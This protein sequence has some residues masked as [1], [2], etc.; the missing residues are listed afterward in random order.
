MAKYVAKPYVAGTPEAEVLGASMIAFTQNL[1][2]DMMQPILEKFNMTDIDPDGWYPHQVWMDILKTIEDTQGAAT[3]QIFV[4]F[5][6][7]VVQ[8]AAMP[9]VIQ[10][11]PD[12]LNALHAIHHANLRNIPET[13]GYAVEQIKPNHFIVYEN[14]PNPSDAIYGFLWGMAAR[15]KKPRELFVVRRIDNPKPDEIPGTAF[16]IKWGLNQKDIE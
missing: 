7:Q 4:A 3:Q 9:P 1:A 5:G 15:F 16:E 11:I 2:A 12:A 14:T 10:S 6:K 13:E 8:T